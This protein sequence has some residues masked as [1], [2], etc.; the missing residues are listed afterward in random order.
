MKVQNLTVRPGFGSGYS[1]DSPLIAGYRP[2]GLK[3][4]SLGEKRKSL[5][6]F[7]INRMGP[8]ILWIT[9]GIGGLYVSPLIPAPADTI[10]KVAGIAALGWGIYYL[11]TEPAAPPSPGSNETTGGPP[12]PAPSASDFQLFSGSII[13]PIS[14]SKP[15][16]NVWTWTNNFDVIVSWHNG[17]KNVA[18][19]PYDIVAD[20]T[21]PGGALI[22][23]QNWIKQV[24]ATKSV[25]DLP[26]GTSVQ[27]AVTIPLIRPPQTG[28]TGGNPNPV[29][30]MFLQLRKIDPKDGTPVPVGDR[31]QVGPFDLDLTTVP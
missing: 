25:K 27:V 26:A 21:I 2:L 19:F 7:S 4:P 12:K 17:S 31:I 9:G 30:Y 8:S 1:Q 15:K 16:L 28:P 3:V 10:L 5:G 6:E 22:Q 29:V 13:S 18:N 23:G 20:A 24:V 14:G 11:F